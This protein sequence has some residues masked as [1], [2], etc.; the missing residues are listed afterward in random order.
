MRHSETYRVYCCCYCNH[1]HHVN[2]FFLIKDVIR[3]VDNKNFI[4]F[5][6]IIW[7]CVFF[8]DLLFFDVRMFL[9]NHTA[10]HHLGEQLSSNSR[11][12]N[13]RSTPPKTPN[14]YI[15]VYCTKEVPSMDALQQHFQTKH[16]KYDHLQRCI[17]PKRCIRL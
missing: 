13:K 15:C 5:L 6:I 11:S 9:Q 4:V 14:Q 7:S 10:T 3:I 8:V 16:C 12:S 2:F 17:T 1:A